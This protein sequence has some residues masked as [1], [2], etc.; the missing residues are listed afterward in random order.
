MLSMTKL[1][2]STL[3]AGIALLAVVGLSGCSMIP[4]SWKAAFGQAIEVTAYF[5]N[6]A[7]LY[8][9]NDVSVLGMPVGQV[10]SV[11]PQGDRVKV[12]MTID[13]DIPV[14]ADATAAI[15]NTSIVTTRHVEL[16]PVYQEGPKLENGSVIQETKAPVSIGELFDAIDG[17][18]V[19]LKGPKGG[20]A[21]LADMIDIT[22]GIADG[23]GEEIRA[24]LEQLGEASE[25]VSGNSD[26][27]VDVI[28]TIE[29]LTTTLVKNYPKMTAFSKSVNEVSE[30]L[31]QQSPGLVATLRNLN[32]TL[33]NTTEFLRGNTNTISVSFDRLAAL[34]AN[35]SD[36]S[37]Q[38]VETIDVAPL[39]F[40]NLSNSI[41]AEQGAGRNQVLLGKSLVDNELLAKFC[42]AIN[43][44]KDGCRT[45]KLKDFGPDLGIY[46]AMWELV[47]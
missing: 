41:S 24:A 28:E 18:V 42:E 21:P 40:Q 44:Q 27:L 13:S 37:R 43:L 5:D 33:Q 8:E 26:A 19:A 22:A 31:G 10:T 45:G 38:V 9:T 4:G 6:V 29:G 7:G 46:S 25:V 1:R 34:T 12:T 23:N 35:L 20:P 15:V 14:P 36:Y 32:Q 16:S 3:L 17:L 47:K 30:L 39:L 11:E 2:R